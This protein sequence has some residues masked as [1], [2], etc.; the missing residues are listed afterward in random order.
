MKQVLIDLKAKPSIRAGKDWDVTKKVC[1][2]GSK[3]IDRMVE[4][5]EITSKKAKRLKPGDCH[6]PRLS[7]YPKI[8][9][10]DVPLRGVVSTVGSPFEHI[11]KELIP[12]LRSLQGRSGLYINNAKELK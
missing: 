9:K 3:I 7:G 12:I 11:S 8:H 4:R 10:P 6:A 2:D 1:R 5:K